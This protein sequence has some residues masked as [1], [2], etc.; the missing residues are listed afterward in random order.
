M[1]QQIYKNNVP[2]ITDRLIDD[3]VKKDLF[4]NPNN[5]LNNSIS[6]NNPYTID[7]LDIQ[8]QFEK[9]YRV[10]IDSSNRNRIP[11]NILDMN[12]YNLDSNPLFFKQDS[13]KVIVKQTNHPFVGDDK[14]IMS[15]VISLFVILKNPFQLTANSPFVKINH[16][17]HGLTDILTKFFQIFI[18]IENAIGNAMNGTYINEIPI[19]LINKK[20]Q[21]YLRINN[22]DVINPNYYFIK[23]PVNSKQNYTDTNNNIKLTY[24][25]LEGI[26]LYY[27]NAN[28][29]L[30]Q[31]RYVGYHVISSIID[32]NSYEITINSPAVRDTT[33]GGFGGNNIVVQKIINTIEGYP[34]QNQYT[35]NLGKT[36][37]SVKKIKI[38]STIF[39][40]TEKIVKNI[41]NGSNQNNY[42]YWE[43]LDDGDIIYS[44]TITAGNY[45]IPSLIT[46]LT[47]QIQKISRPTITLLS[48]NDGTNSPIEYNNYNQVSISID[49]I[50]DIFTIQFFTNVTLS[51]AITKSNLIYTDNHDRIQINQLN[52]NRIVGDIV[53]LS[54][55]IST[56]NIP[57][58]ILNNSFTIES[59]IDNNNYIVKLPLYNSDSS[60]ITRGGNL[61]TISMPI[62]ARLLFNQSNTLGQILG[63]RNVGQSTSITQ[64]LYEIKNN[65]PYENDFVLDETGI[66]QLIDSNT[67]KNNLINLSNVSYI[68][69][70]CP[71]ILNENSDN[72]NI[73]TNNIKNVMA[74]INLYGEIG[75]YIYDSFILLINDFDIPVPSISELQF[76]FVRPDGSLYDFNNIDHSFVLEITEDLS[77]LL[78]ADQNTRTGR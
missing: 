27:L 31:D 30:N 73:V 18:L 12:F 15:N 6:L 40:I 41:S 66:S 78:N 51:Q 45:D 14:I 33:S 32:S 34:Q 58:S 49:S 7:S 35:I 22:T 43:L 38:L 63:F 75:S 37:T 50:T 70:V 2:K 46:E 54:N 17:N 13:N 10:N 1:Q 64:F 19:S 5:I 48:I 65:I 25:N 77:Q 29:P 11:K 39:P 42:F 71:I 53:I 60:S 57:A 59:I 16:P 74:K 56:D 52:H 67:I 24:L 62:K 47:S 23:L 20:Q 28:Y 68:Y 8:T 55:A 4:L 36:F 9:T 26:P 44:T 69:M 76:S 72:L 21:V 3:P 61:I